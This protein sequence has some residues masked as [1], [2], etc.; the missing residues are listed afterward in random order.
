MKKLSKALIAMLLMLSLTLFVS[1]GKEDD[2]D[3]D[4][5]DVPTIEF[6]EGSE[7]EGTQSVI[8][9]D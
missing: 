2:D 8:I 3:D 5:G 7:P 1:C 9:P 6:P 4:S